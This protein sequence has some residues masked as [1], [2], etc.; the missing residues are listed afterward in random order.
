VGSG[1]RL[2]RCCHFVAAIGRQVQNRQVQNGH[3]KPGERWALVSRAPGALLAVTLSLS[4]AHGQTVPQLVTRELV[5]A[6]NAARVK[7]GSPPLAWSDRLAETAHRWADYLM[8]AHAFAPRT[9]DP[10]GETLLLIA[11]GTVAP[12]EVVRTWLSEER[13]YNHNTNSCIGV[14]GHYTQV[15]WRAAR[16]VGC[17]MAFDGYRQIWVCEY[18]PPGNFTGMRPY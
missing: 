18:A 6:H 7:V 15:V 12:A 16:E 8:A 13:D 2:R 1:L 17:G 3:A 5:A 11:G 14:C 10:H 4:A 9:G